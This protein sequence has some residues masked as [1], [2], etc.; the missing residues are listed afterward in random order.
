MFFGIEGT[1][2]F[3]NEIWYVDNVRAA[4]RCPPCPNGVGCNGDPHFKTWRG[5]HFD[6]HGECDLVLLHS[7]AFESGLGL[8]VQIRAKI[9]H[10]ASY[11]SGAALRIGKDFLE[12]ESQ[13]VYWLNGVLNADLPDDFSGFAFS[14]PPTSSMSRRTRTLFRS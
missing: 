6:Y 10:H 9:C 2:G 1:P 7:S 4:G 13:G 11:I 5:Q 8:D 12:V 3:A 14:R